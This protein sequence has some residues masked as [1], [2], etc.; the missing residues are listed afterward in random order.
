MSDEVKPLADDLSRLVRAERDISDVPDD[1]QARVMAR[2]MKSVVPPSSGN[3]ESGGGSNGT[4]ARAATSAAIRSP[5]LLAGVFALGVATGVIGDR[6][7]RPSSNAV[8][9]AASAPAV[10]PAPA[11]PETPSSPSPESDPV[12]T[13]ASPSPLPTTKTTAAP[14]VSVSPARQLAD[15]QAILDIA[16]AAL[17]RGGGGAALEAVERHERRYPGGLLSEE[18]EVL[19][20]EALVLAGRTDDARA[21]ADRFE[22][23]YPRSVLLP[24][25]QAAVAPASINDK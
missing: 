11:E 8:P 24:T 20:I 16:R 15:E 17:N 18:R 3:G 13:Y 10:K 2:L 4:V 19:A 25:V 12:R 14:S 7:A 22:K 6:L 21:R 23:R 1:A 9:T 5:A